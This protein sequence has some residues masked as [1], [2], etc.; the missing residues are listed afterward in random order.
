MG[1][2]RI[3]RLLRCFSIWTLLLVCPP[4]ALSQNPFKYTWP[5]DS[6][7]VITGNYGEL[8][9]NHFHAG[10][11]FAT[12][13]KTNL[14]VYSIEDGYVSRIRI[15]PYGYGKCVYITHPGGKVSVY[16]HLNAF[17]L[18]IANVAKTF[19]NATQS[20]EIDFMPRPKTVY[21]RK[22]EIIGLSG[23]TGGST[24]PHLHF[25]IRDEVSEVPLNP[26]GFFR[27]ND[28]TAPELHAIAFFSLAD[29][30]AP[31]LLKTLRVRT[32]EK[33]SLI[34]AEDHLELEESIVGLAFSGFDRMSP[35]G[36]PNNIY[37]ARIYV[38]DRLIYSHTLNNIAFSESRFINEF[39]Q[40]ISRM[41]YQKC[42]L[43]ESYPEG[44]FGNCIN[45]GRIRLM[46]T[47]FH[48]IRLIVSDESGNTRTLQFY[49]KAK[50]LNTYRAPKTGGDVRISCNRIFNGA[51]NGISLSVPAKTL[52]YST[53]LYI[54]NFLEEDGKFSIL[55]QVNLKQPALIGFKVPQRFLRNREKLILKGAPGA[56]PQNR[57]DSV[58]FLVK[59]FGNYRLDMDTIP[60]KVKV[61]Y[62]ERRLKEAWQMDAFSFQITD[63]GSGIG[64]YNLWLNNAWV[65]AEYDARTDLL[66]YYFDEDTPIGLLRFKLEVEDKLGNKT[67]FEYV[68]KK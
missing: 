41:K 65:I 60:P 63:N 53:G 16:A 47:T 35:A 51:K 28:R 12:G 1:W 44:M 55:P 61:S 42:F 66:T 40:P 50:Q 9:P 2:T 18:K 45:K 46:D 10:I 13:G 39:S 34:L 57:K 6:P 54:N 59:D 27:I 19:Q 37:S 56:L 8:R 29:T 48:K 21:V 33:D 23:N 62:S 32:A 17:S 7:H 22:N 67:S 58:Y 36:N 38:N 11:D 26:L 5:L 25:E 68:L 20:N 30:S 3:I 64:K 43:P 52:F 15:S 24:G 4:A 31:Q 49:I 14:Q